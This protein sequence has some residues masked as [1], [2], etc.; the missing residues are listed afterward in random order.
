[1]SY[2]G[3][4]GLRRLL[5]DRCGCTNPLTKREYSPEEMRGMVQNYI[6]TDNIHIIELLSAL[7][8][9]IQNKEKR[10]KK[11]NRINFNKEV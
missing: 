5:R 4:R 9:D 3:N 6:D 11:K 7:C 10:R 8:A 1:M 2:L